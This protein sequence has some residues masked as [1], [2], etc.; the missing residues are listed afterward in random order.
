MLPVALVAYALVFVTPPAGACTCTTYDTRQVLSESPAAFVG[1]LIDRQEAPIP[2]GEPVGGS[3]D[4]TYRFRVDQ[5]VKGD[6]GPEVAVHSPADASSCGISVPT[7][8]P[9]ALILTERDG[10]WLA[11]LCRQPHPDRLL[12]AAEPLPAPDGTLPPDLLIGTTYGLSRSVGLGFDGR[13][14]ALGA[15]PG[16]TVTLAVCPGKERAVEVFTVRNPDGGQTPGVAVRRLATMGLDAQHLLTDRRDLPEAAVC[17]DPDGRD[18][19]LFTRDASGPEPLARVLRVADGAVGVLWEGPPPKAA[20]FSPD[21]KTAYLNLA[22]E[23]EE[24]VA[25]DIS[26]TDGSPAGARTVVR[27]PAGSGPM[28]LSPDGKRL[29]TVS[30]AEN[31]ASRAVI[32]NLTNVNAV[33]TDVDL[34][35]AGINGEMTW[36]GPDRVVFTPRLRPAEPVRV[37]SADLLLVA[38]WTGWTAERSVVSGDRLYGVSQGSVRSAA[39]LTG[40]GAVIREME[41]ALV[42]AI[43]DVSRHEPEDER[44]VAGEPPPSSSTTTTTTIVPGPTSTRPPSSTT[45]TTVAAT[46]T[47]TPLVEPPVEPATGPPTGQAAPAARSEQARSG[48]GGGGIALLLLAA[49]AISGLAGGGLLWRR[50]Q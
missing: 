43:A 11:S 27:V 15:G 47:T 14:G 7:E 20:A 18:V 6:L 37:Y 42:F 36:A 44:A 26:A 41:D 30:Y 1:T 32:V 40:P 16:T 13:I 3:R 9:V 50:R 8:R 12:R 29:A 5:R 24:V 19:V 34:G 17:R 49:L 28:A 39:L 45:T 38:A 10:Q 35:G 23:G 25:L 31:R 33:V 2:D 22:P 21:G 48:G 4:V 46:T